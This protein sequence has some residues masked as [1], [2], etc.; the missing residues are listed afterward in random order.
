MTRTPMITLLLALAILL[1]GSPVFAHGAAITASI[2]D[3]KVQTTSLY[4]DK[5]PMKDASV[6]VYG[7]DGNQVVEGKT[8]SDGKFSFDLPAQS[9]TLKIVVRDLLGHRAETTLNP[10]EK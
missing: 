8:D 3:G 5:S 1:S 10:K 7:P 2:V 9:G 6:H 4:P